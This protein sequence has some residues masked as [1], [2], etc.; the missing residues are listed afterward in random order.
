MA[1]FENATSLAAIKERMSGQPA[2]ASFSGLFLFGLLDDLREDF[3]AWTDL[4]GHR[5]RL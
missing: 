3:D 5:V 4:N 2:F 1:V